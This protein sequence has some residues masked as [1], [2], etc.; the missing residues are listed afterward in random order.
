MLAFMGGTTSVPS[1]GS[2]GS[3][4]RRKVTLCAHFSRGR[5][6]CGLPNSWVRETASPGPDQYRPHPLAPELSA[7]T[8]H[9]DSAQGFNPG[10]RVLSAMRPERAQ[11]SVRPRGNVHLNNVIRLP[12]PNLPP[13][14]GGFG[15][16]VRVPRVETLAE[17]S[18]P[19]GVS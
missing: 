8:G 4:T 14:Q 12:I 19:F 10:K 3:V 9:K 11:V 5:E 2:F 13:L 6:N 17:F 7:P 15:I 18:R 1:D 16:I